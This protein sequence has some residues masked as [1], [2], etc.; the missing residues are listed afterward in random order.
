MLRRPDLCWSDRRLGALNLTKILTELILDSLPTFTTTFPEVAPLGTDT[1]I[2][3]ALQ[4]LGW[5]GEKR[6]LIFGQLPDSKHN[7]SIFRQKPKSKKSCVI[8]A[9]P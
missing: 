8:I 4:L 5:P 6:N 9:W 3:V 2:D 1:T 7:C